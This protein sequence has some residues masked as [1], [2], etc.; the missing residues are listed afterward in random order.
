MH[1]AFLFS[2]ATSRLLTATKTFLLQ[3]FWIR[4]RSVAR[5]H[6]SFFKLRS[7]V[8]LTQKKRSCS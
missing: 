6:V 2:V 1:A 5:V 8:V 7:E 4:V 3:G